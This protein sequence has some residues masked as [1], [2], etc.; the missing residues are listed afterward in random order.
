MSDTWYFAYG[1]NLSV[2]QKMFRT[3]A[4]R[5]AVRCRLPGYRFAFNK[6]MAAGEGMYA[7]VVRDDAA[8]VWGVAYLC[9]DDAV[10]EL[11]R[12]EGVSW[13]HYRREQVEVVTDDGEVLEA[14]TYVA[15]Q[16]YVGDEGWPLPHY[17]RM[18]LDGARDHGLPE[19]YI[20]HI[21][22]LGGGLAE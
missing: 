15:G 5:R 21:E 13:G 2:D 19:E 3:G 7:N 22:E 16:R 9:D 12:F 11:D 4:I 17:L 10:A 6:R 14:L 8:T 1:S 20:E 18:I